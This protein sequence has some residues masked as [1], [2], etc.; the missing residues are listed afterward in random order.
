MRPVPLLILVTA[1]STSAGA[2]SAVIT[3]TSAAS[4]T[5]E[6]IEAVLGPLTPTTEAGLPEGWTLSALITEEVEIYPY[7]GAHQPRETMT[8]STFLGSQRV[9]HVLEERPD[10][11]LQV[12]VPRRPNGTTGWIRARDVTVFPVDKR[13]VVD[14]SDRKLTVYTGSEI[15]LTT[16]VA[17]GRPSNPTPTGEF[18]VT[19]AVVL[20]NPGGP[21]GP[22]A[23]GLS[24]FSDTITEFN[25]GDAV[26]AIHGTN[27]PSSIGN[28]QS[29][30]CV[31]VPNQVARALSEL[32]SAGVPVTIQD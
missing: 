2:G 27:A 5:S 26:V 20:T 22:N 23:F 4:V 28:A 18:F 29:L 21:W 11:W 8:S 24:A 19:D 6:D 25:G 10:G 17:I 13:V 7:P 30:G 14:L 3:P 32:I 16:T 9:F 31:R 12:M 15:T 1:C